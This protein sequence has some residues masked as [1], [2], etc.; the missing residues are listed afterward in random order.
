MIQV[1]QQHLLRFPDELGHLFN[2]FANGRF[3]TFAAQ[4]KPSTE[5]LMVK[6][7]KNPVENRVSAH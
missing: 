3:R 5:T 2:L 7:L 4:V 1:S 6:L